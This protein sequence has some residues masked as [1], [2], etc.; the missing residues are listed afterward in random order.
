MNRLRLLLL[1][2]AMSLA[3]NAQAAPDSSNFQYRFGGYFKSLLT[4]SHSFFTGDAY[5]DDLNR[6][7]LSFDGGWRRSLLVHVEYDNELHFG[8][9]IS[10]PDFNL[11]R[12]RQDDSYFDLL[13]I[14]VDEKHAYWDTSL[15]RGYLTLHY[16]NMELTVGRQRIAWG[17]AHFW[18]PTDVFNPISPLQIE[19]DERQGADAA[20]LS[21]RLPK[22]VRWSLVYAPQNGINRSTEATRIARTI[23]NFDVAA[24]GGRFAE[25]W[26][27]GGNFAGQWRGAGLRGELTYTWRGNRSLLKSSALR[28]TLGSD[29]AINNKWYVLG[30]YFY[31][32]GQPAGFTPG[33]G[34]DPSVLLRFTNQIFTLQHQFVSVGARY[35]V[36]P[37]LNLQTY[38]VAEPAGPSVFF[39]PVVSYN[40]SSNTDLSS[41]GQLFASS[42]SGEFHNVPNLFY[43]EFTVHF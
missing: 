12:Q 43:L 4:T 19:A 30:E 10:E 23:H 16:N 37:L 6:L 21:L 5:G 14:W 40:L 25:D 18:S 36:T 27:I 38:A 15:Y 41:G 35:S 28:W 2:L 42:P 9:L 20:Q 7:R 22:R 33:Q 24:L 29:Y 34:F 32:Q 31:N 11:V 13:H 8:N 17:T 1:L 3:A 39:M 26:M